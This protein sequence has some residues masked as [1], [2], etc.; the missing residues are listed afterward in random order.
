M[1][2]PFIR[3]L[4]RLSHSTE[5]PNEGLFRKAIKVLFDI[6][7]AA[8]RMENPIKFRTSPQNRSGPTNPISEQEFDKS[9]LR[10]REWDWSETGMETNGWT[11]KKR[12]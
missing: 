2:I 4:I 7:L 9:R 12:E 10:E 1:T 11:G 3:P 6:W 5:S 8:P